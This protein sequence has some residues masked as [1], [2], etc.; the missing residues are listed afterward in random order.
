[1]TSPP[2]AGSHRRRLVA[3]P[4]KRSP[5]AARSPARSLARSRQTL[6]VSPLSSTASPTNF[7]G[8]LVEADLPAEATVTGLVPPEAQG[9]RRMATALH[10]RPASPLAPLSRGV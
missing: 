3:P 8:G 4:G 5:V 7:Q 10:A 1:M 9:R 6:N 2:T